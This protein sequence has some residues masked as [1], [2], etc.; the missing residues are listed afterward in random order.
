MGE[1]NNPFKY[2][3]TGYLRKQCQTPLIFLNPI[4]LLSWFFNVK[5]FANFS[6]GTIKKMLESMLLCCSLP[7]ESVVFEHVNV[8]T[9][10]SQIISTEFQTLL[11]FKLVNVIIFV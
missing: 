4:S 1:K 5:T 10:L 9:Y 6:L 3:T 8:Q 2:C 11:L 7:L